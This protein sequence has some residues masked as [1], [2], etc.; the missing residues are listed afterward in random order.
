VILER[1]AEAAAAA[2]RSPW[3]WTVVGFFVPLIGLIAVTPL[4]PAE[5]V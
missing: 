5:E 1:R 4:R 2:W 3:L